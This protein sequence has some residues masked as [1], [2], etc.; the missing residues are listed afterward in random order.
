MPL[1]IYA[2]HFKILVN[3]AGYAYI[4]QAH[5]G[6]TVRVYVGN[7]KLDDVTVLKNGNINVGR[8][9][10]GSIAEVYLL[11]DAA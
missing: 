11:R 1:P 7:T 5:V 6:R 8:K 3:V 2:P 10:T 9:Y 4:G